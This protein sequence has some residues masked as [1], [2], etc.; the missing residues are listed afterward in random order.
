MAT[1]DITKIDNITVNTGISALYNTVVYDED[2]EVL[3]VAF[4]DSTYNDHTIKSYSHNGDFDSLTL[5]DS[6]TVVTISA[7]FHICKLKGQRCLQL[8]CADETLTNISYD[9][10]GDTLNEEDSIT[11]TTESMTTNAQQIVPLAADESM[12]VFAE[13]DGDDVWAASFSTNNSTYVITQYDEV[14]VIATYT[15]QLSATELDDTHV[16][17][18]Y[19]YTYAISGYYMRAFILEVDG[20][21]NISRTSILTVVPDSA[22]IKYFLPS[23]SADVKAKRG[24]LTF[25][26]DTEN[27]YAATF[28]WNSSY[29]LST[30]NTGEIIDS[31][32]YSDS[33]GGICCAAINKDHFV[34]AFLGGSGDDSIVYSGEFDGTNFTEMDTATYYTT[35]ASRIKSIIH[36]GKGFIAHTEARTGTNT[37]VLYTDHIDGLFGN[38][39][40]FFNFM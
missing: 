23:V 5:I 13:G 11:F 18:V 34:S 35:Y 9:A 37:F 40:G 39:G 27:A 17:G 14:E 2:I 8:V 25:I 38:G 36:C 7:G 10:D 15:S 33:L 20:S 16:L 3:F 29:A 6:I 1:Y 32:G 12:A 26:G 21:L 24:F 22:T 31:N 30:E 4:Y 28:K 19:D